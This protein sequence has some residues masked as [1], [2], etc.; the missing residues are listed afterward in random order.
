MSRLRLH[1]SAEGRTVLD[2]DVDECT[3]L[4]T[5]TETDTVPACMWGDGA[6]GLWVYLPGDSEPYQIAPIEPM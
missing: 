4:V 6:D 3:V 2:R 5:D 1:V